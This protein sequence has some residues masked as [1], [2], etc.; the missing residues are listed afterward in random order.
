LKHVEHFSYFLLT[1]LIWHISHQYTVV[2]EVVMLADVVFSWLEA[3]S[4]LDAGAL[5]LLTWMI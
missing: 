1:R 3:A 2:D 5:T 4:E